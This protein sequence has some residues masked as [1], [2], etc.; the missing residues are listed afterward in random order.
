MAPEAQLLPAA[1]LSG[2]DGVSGQDPKIH[3]GFA[4]S[5]A[6]RAAVVQGGDFRG[7][8]DTVIEAHIVDE[9]VEQAGG[10]VRPAD[11]CRG[12]RSMPLNHICF[13]FKIRA[14]ILHTDYNTGQV[15]CY[16]SAR[17]LLRRVAQTAV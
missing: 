3:A 5:P 16:G 1:P 12:E 2:Q 6:A 15:T 17:P 14:G 8:E 7:G 11:P 13:I 4:A 10:K 9:P